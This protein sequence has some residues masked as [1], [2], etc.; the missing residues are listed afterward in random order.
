MGAST[1]EPGAENRLSQP[2]TDHE[3]SS[4]QTGVSEQNGSSEVEAESLNSS[5]IESDNTLI[6]IQIMTQHRRGGF[7]TFMYLTNT[8][9]GPGI[10]AVSSTFKTTGIGPTIIIAIAAALLCY[11]SS[12]LFISIHHKLEVNT[13]NELADKTF[14]GKAARVIL[15]ILCLFFDLTLA[16]TNLVIGT[17]QVKSWLSLTGLNLLGFKKW[18]LILFLYTLVIPS[19]LTIP[20]H[21]EFLD[22]FQKL[23]VFGIVLYAVIITIKGFTVG[24]LPAETV[25]GYCF[26]MSAFTSFAVHV[27]SFCLPI[28]LIPLIVH[29]NPKK[30]RRKVISGISLIFDF[31]VIV[32]PGVVGYLTYGSDVK[33]D[34][35]NSYPSNGMF[36]LIFCS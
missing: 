10:V 2:G 9:L 25:I 27:S 13:L 6:P 29:Y 28:H 11:I 14:G 17:D 19:M 26:D 24:S 30:I 31:I 21:F 32:T 16:S 4:E 3:E 20:R 35:L 5:R 34:V 18:C 22:G 12:S 1:S 8:L 7:V 36:H 23:T 33:S 15:S